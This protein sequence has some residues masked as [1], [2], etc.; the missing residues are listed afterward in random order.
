MVEEMVFVHICSP[1]TLLGRTGVSS[2]HKIGLWCM[3][4]M[5]VESVKSCYLYADWRDWVRDPNLSG[6]WHRVHFKAIVNNICSC[7]HNICPSILLLHNSKVK[8]GKSVC[9][10]L[11]IIKK[12]TSTVIMLCHRLTNS[13]WNILLQ[14]FFYFY[15]FTFFINHKSIK[16]QWSVHHKTFMLDNIFYR[17][18]ERQVKRSSGDQW[19]QGL[20]SVPSFSFLDHFD[21]Y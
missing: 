4:Y 6:L 10:T 1:Q 9:L 16:Y 18:P 13:Y 5:Q 8:S 2:V 17:S 21:V 7:L 20:C 19:L 12:G 11:W 14:T 3:H 15:F